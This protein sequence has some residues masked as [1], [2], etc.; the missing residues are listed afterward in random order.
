[1]K[2]QVQ[3]GLAQFPK[4]GTEGPW[5]LQHAYEHDFERLRKGPVNDPELLF[6]KRLSKK[7]LSVMNEPS[8][9]QIKAQA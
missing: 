2:R 9:K 3:R 5:T 8:T 1:Y 6:I 7:K 4:A